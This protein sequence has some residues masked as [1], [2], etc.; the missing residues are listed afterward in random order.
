MSTEQF[1]K[2]EKL[3]LESK[4][5]GW[6]QCRYKFDDLI[7]PDCN[8]PMTDYDI[9][10]LSSNSDNQHLIKKLFDEYYIDIVYIIETQ[11][12]CEA[13]EEDYCTLHAANRAAAN[14]P[15]SVYNKIVNFTLQT[16][17]EDIRPLERLPIDGPR[18]ED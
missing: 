9:K 15:W 1:T 18:K 17:E 7:D 3:I 11:E 10:F 2:E 8:H 4:W 5:D 14:I 6:K 12:I 16:C 13:D